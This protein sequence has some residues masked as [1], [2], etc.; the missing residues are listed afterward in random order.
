MNY[1]CYIDDVLSG[2]NSI[3]EAIQLQNELTTL[4]ESGKFNFRKWRA[5][6]QEIL[7]NIANSGRTDDLL[8]LNSKESF[9]TLG[10][11][12]NCHDD[13]LQFS[14]NIPD[15][16]KVTKRRIL[17]AIAQIYD[18][19]GILGPVIITAKIFIQEL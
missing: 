15:I 7:Q 14:I 1:D 3:S 13:T 16:T 11:L 4:L 6:N 18:P 17:S 19:L 2:A 9:K 5:N 12:W 10:L 8:I